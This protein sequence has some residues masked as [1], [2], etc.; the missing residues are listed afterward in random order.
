VVYIS[1]SKTEVHYC[2]EEY[3]NRFEILI[4]RKI[5]RFRCDHGR[6]YINKF[7]ENSTFKKGIFL[8][9]SPP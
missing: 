4:G 2:F 1:K 6:E 7:I 8:E 5:K 3:V 9:P